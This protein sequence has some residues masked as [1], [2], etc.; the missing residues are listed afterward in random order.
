M[1]EQL[2][3]YLQRMDEVEASTQKLQIGTNSNPD[4]SETYIKKIPQIES[5]DEHLLSIAKERQSSKIFESYKKDL[6]K[7][8]EENNAFK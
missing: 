3:M 8:A 4:Q 1:Q 5:S 7:D 2:Q 6:E